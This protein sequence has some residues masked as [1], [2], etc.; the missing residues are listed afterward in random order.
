[1]AFYL[2][3]VAY[4]SS[5]AKTL[6][7]NPQTREDAIKKTCASLGG[8]LQSFYFSFGEYDVVVIA[9]LPDNAAA[10]SFALATAAKG[11]ISKFHTT[12][13]LTPA[14]GVKAMKKAQKVDYTPPA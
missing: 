6:I 4:S 14:E 2:I 11:A 5:A 3:Q 10:A 12:V 8:K 7:A 13:L 9:E 1:M